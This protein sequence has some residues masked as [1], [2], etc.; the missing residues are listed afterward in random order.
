M[1]SY[2]HRSHRRRYRRCYYL[3]SMIFA[4]GLWLF[5]G[6]AAQAAP[7]L[8]L[9]AQVFQ[10]Q[11]AGCHVGGGNIVRRGKNLRLKA[12]AKNHVD[13]PETVEALVIEGKGNMA[14]Y[15][16]RLSSEEISAVAAYVLTQ[17]QNDWK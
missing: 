8:E 2:R 11:C 10:A 13:S 12:L 3:I 5:S 15:G 14:A 9:G 7:N 17:A 1:I 6:S 16:D 4:L